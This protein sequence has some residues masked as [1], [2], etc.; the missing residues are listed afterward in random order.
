[1]ERREQQPALAQ[2]LWAVEQEDGALADQRP[3]RRVGLSG[4]QHLRRGAE[5]L[6]HLV[7]PG[8]DH[9]VA[10]AGGAEDEQVAVPALAAREEALRR[11][12]EEGRL[13]EGREARAGRKRDGPIIGVVSR[14]ASRWRSGGGDPRRTRAPGPG[15]FT[16]AT[17]PPIRVTS[18]QPGAPAVSS[19]TVLCLEN[20]AVPHVPAASPA[21]DDELALRELLVA[22]RGARGGNFSERLETTR[23]GILGEIAVESNRLA[24]SREELESQWNALREARD[25][26]E[27]EASQVALSSGYKSELLANLSHEL[28]T[29]LT[30]LLFLAEVLSENAEGNLSDRQREFAR[31]IHGAGS[32][33]LALINDILDLSQVEAGRMDVHAA[34]VP[35]DRVVDD[36]RRSFAAVAVDRGLRFDVTIDEAAPE[37]LHVDD[38]RLTQV[39]RNLLANAFKF[40]ADGVVALRVVPTPDG[41]AF[42]VSDTGIGIA[43]EKLRVVFEAFQQADGTTSRRYGGTG[44]GLSISREIAR[45]LGGELRVESIAGTGSTFTLRLPERYVAPDAQ[46]GLQAAGAEFAPGLE[47]MA[48]AGGPPAG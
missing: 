32:D 11:E 2:V 30:S 20:R 9:E 36:L 37:T 10:E 21:S 12:D 44:L 3:E 40:T 35:V 18:A 33:L 38:Q 25:E 19:G 43:P 15:A 1:V 41:V 4:S 7:G 39:L 24:E 22:L 27:E 31:T 42:A 6:T 48:M 5:H 46:E 29:P 16:D 13:G 23:A 8:D 28:R 26:L 17:L 14:A 47:A 45:V 34:E